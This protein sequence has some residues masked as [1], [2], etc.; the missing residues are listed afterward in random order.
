[1][2]TRRTIGTES[3]V[4]AALTILAV[5]LALLGAANLTLPGARL[6][7]RSAPPLSLS[8]PDTIGQVKARVAAE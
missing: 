5:V 2:R 4:P 1:M 6:K 3:R 8:Q 7:S